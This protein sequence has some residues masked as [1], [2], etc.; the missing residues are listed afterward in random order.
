ML[1]RRAYL[2]SMRDAR[3]ARRSSWERAVNRKLRAK[4]LPSGIAVD[5]ETM[6]HEL[7]EAIRRTADRVAAR[8]SKIPGQL[9]AA[10]RKQKIKQQQRSGAAVDIHK[11]DDWVSMG[12]AK[13]VP[14]RARTGQ[15]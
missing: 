5:D 2:R 9:A 1:A 6:A 12:A 14:P 15:K 7:Q 10:A 3:I 11:V 13:R 8:L 4:V